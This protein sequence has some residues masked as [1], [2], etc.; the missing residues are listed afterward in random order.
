MRTLAVL[1]LSGA[2][3]ALTLARVDWWLPL[4]L[5]T[6]A[7]WLFATAPGGEEDE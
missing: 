6:Y 7:G 4:T 3:I 1:A 5:S 2:A